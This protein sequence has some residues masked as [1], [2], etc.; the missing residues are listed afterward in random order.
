MRYILSF[1]LSFFI[2][3]LTFSQ[4]KTFKIGF[5]LDKNSVEINELLKELSD[6]ISA[7]VGEDAV[8]EFPEVSKLVNNFDSSTALNNYNVLV[9]NNTDIII[10]F[11]VVNNAVISKIGTYQKPTIVFGALSE[12]LLTDES[13]VSN[14]TNYT[15]IVTSQSYIEDIKLLQKLASPKTI[16]V[17][18]EKAFIDNLPIASTFNDISKDLNIEIKLI[19]FDSLSDITSNL[20]NI[21][22]VYLAGGFYLSDS[23]MQELAN[24]LIEKR[25][26]SFTSNPVKDVINGILATSHDQSELNQFFR[27]I[28]LTV[29]SI[30]NGN[31]LST[32]STK[33][34]S[35]STL[36]V[37][38]NT[39]EKIG[40]PLK[41]SLIAST[42]FVGNPKEIVADKTYTLVSVMQ[43][44]ITENLELQTID[45]DISLTKKDLELAK[46][47][48]LPNITAGV[49]GTYVDPQLAEV[50][51]GQ[52]PEITTSGNITLQQ[53]IFSEAANANI[54]IQKSLRD[55][56]QENYNSEALNTVFNTATAYFTALILKANLSI[57][58]QNLEL[59]KYNLKI[60]TENYEAGQAGKSDVLRFKSEMAQ[61]TQQMVEAINKL[62]Q[63]Y[64]V[65]NQLLNNPIDTKIDVEEAELKKG[66]FSNYNYEQL[67][68]F[69]DDPT[70]RFPFIKFLVQEAINNA[71]EL[72]ALDYNVKATERSER[73]YGAGRFLPTF[74]L[75][76][77]YNY[78]F[79]RSGTGSS[80]PSGFPVI[81]DGYYTVGLN[82]SLPI[83]NQN[84]QN[85][86]KQIATLQ[87]EQLEISRDN[88][89][90]NI[91]KNINDAVLQLINQ[92]SN[93]QLSKVFEDTAKE[94]LDLTQTSY[95]NGAVNIVQLLDAQNNYLQAQLAS[96][97]ATYNYLQSSMQLERSLGLFFLLQDESERTAFIQRFLKFTQNND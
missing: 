66:V 26:P 17:V 79:S 80:F 95:A 18:V 37:N 32:L 23:E 41:Y 70:L 94:A 28:A 4:D 54:S 81:P 61:N 60:A 30:L 46:S 78:E 56:Q 7:V 58:N 8:L 59:T 44:A 76:G 45:K 25:L 77:Q 16:G 84:R 3:T 31:A 35:K 91:E 75:Q 1:F 5:L 63:G 86:N 64:Y 68:Q 97:N 82:V 55:A 62:E 73:L 6:E 12:E 65:L 29:E 87:K 89:T 40:L 50:S 21:D 49:T 51:N 85:I 52:S 92:I 53:T 96:A 2:T 47:D 24:V 38:Y 67:G 57:Q 71:P 42:S 48:Y 20:D 13:L 88:I 14:I 15:S 90:L 69:L 22:A 10:A 34:E 33:L 27:R 83:F 36:T 19:P 39:A 93:I 74:A 43:E 11:G 72:K 9:K